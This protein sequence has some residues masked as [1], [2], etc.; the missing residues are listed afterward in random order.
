MEITSEMKER[1]G[2]GTERRSAATHWLGGLEMGG[3]RRWGALS[4]APARPELG[5]P[6]SAWAK[7]R[8]E[9]R[10]DG[11]QKKCRRQ[12]CRRTA[13]RMVPNGGTAEV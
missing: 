6:V 3:G 9:S 1:E 13:R 2:T 7:V 8:R 12:E 4:P 10:Q 11:A 5:E